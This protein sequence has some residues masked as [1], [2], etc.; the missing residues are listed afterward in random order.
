MCC[1]VAESEERG[2]SVHASLQVFSA[3]ARTVNSALKESSK[4]EHALQQQR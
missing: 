1:S 2:F 3:L 4:R